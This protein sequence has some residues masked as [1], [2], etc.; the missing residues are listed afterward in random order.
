MTEILRIDSITPDPEIL[1]HAG[2]V[3][4]QGGLVAYPTE[5]VYGLAAS[6]FVVDS[7]ARVF[8]AKG[9][10]F[11][12]PLPVQIAEAGEVETL[13][14]NVSAAARRLIADFFPGPLTL[15]FWRQPT[16]SL[17][18]TGGGNTVGLRMPDHPVALGVLRAFGAPLVCPSANLTGRR[19]S[20]S[21]QDVL[22]DLDG[23]IDLVLDG[24]PTTDRTPSTV[25]DVTTEPAR[26]IRE[27]KISRAELEV[28]LRIE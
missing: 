20:M 10:P 2:E 6:A 19:A 26:L 28:Y 9:R 27:G 17:T 1:A 11:G 23:E 21:A 13:A 15:V 25:L 14:R 24:G 4:R 16:V 3:L 12:Q 22:E 18:V 5:T 7:I 8:D